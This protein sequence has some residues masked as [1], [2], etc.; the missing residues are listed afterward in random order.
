MIFY[1]SIFIDNKV[2]GFFSDLRNISRY[3]GGY[4]F[5]LFF[6][7]LGWAVIYLTGPMQRFGPI[8]NLYGLE[9]LKPI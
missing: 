7:R 9:I 5:E 2:L 8:R 1:Y 6:S 4:V 3:V